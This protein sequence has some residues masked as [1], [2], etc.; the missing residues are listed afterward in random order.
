MVWQ[1]VVLKFLKPFKGFL[2]NVLILFSFNSYFLVPVNQ[3][4]G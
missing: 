4:D 2:T 1:Q 3:V